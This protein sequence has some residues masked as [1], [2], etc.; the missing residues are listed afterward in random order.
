MKRKHYLLN[1][2][3]LLLCFSGRSQEKIELYKIPE[4][5]EIVDYNKT[6][7]EKNT[8]GAS[9]YLLTNWQSNLIRKTFFTHFA[10]KIN[11]NEGVQEMS[12]LDFSFD[13]SY[14]KINF[15]FINV[16]RD[17]RIINKITDAKIQTIQKEESSKRLLYDGSLTTI[18]NLKD[19]R[20]N[21]II[22]YAY[23]RIGMNPISKGSFSKTAYLEYTIPV[24]LI[25]H[26]IITSKEINYKTYSGAPTPKIK[27]TKYGTEYILI[28]TNSK[29]VIYDKNTPNWY[30]QQ[31]RV[32]FST[33]NNWND[34]V[35]WALPHYRYNSK[36]KPLEFTNARTTEHKIIQT[37]RF[38]QDEVRYLGFED[39]ISAYK[40][41]SPQKIYSQRYGDCKDKSLLLVTL[42]K[43]I[44]VKAYPVLVN[45]DSKQTIIN[46]LPSYNTFNHCIVQIDYQDQQYFI[47][48]TIS[49]QGGD[50]K[51]HENPNYFFG[52]VIKKGESNLTSI[53]VLQKASTDVK[54]TF[55]MDSIGGDCILEVVTTYKGS[56]AD[57]NRSYFKSNSY[58]EIQKKYTEFYSYQHPEIQ[59]IEEIEVEDWDRNTTN[60]FIVKEKYKIHNFWYDDEEDEKTIHCETSPLGLQSLIDYSKA[61]NRNMPYYLGPPK[62]YHHTTYIKVPEEWSITGFYDEVIDSSFTYKAKATYQNK[63]IT[64]TYDYDLKKHFLKKNEV[65]SFLEKHDKIYSETG[66]TLSYE[67]NSDHSGMSWHAIF[68]GLFTF[69]LTLYFLSK[70]YTDFNP[71]P[72]KYSN[73][74]LSLGGVLYFVPIGLLASLYQ[75]AISFH[76][77]EPFI[78]R[79]WIK[80]DTMPNSN[81][82]LMIASA[83]YMLHIFFIGFN[84][85]LLILFFKKRT[86]TSILTSAFYL[87]I[88]AIPMLLKLTYNLFA[89]NDSLDVFNDSS[90]IYLLAFLAWTGYFTYSERPKK[91][92]VNVY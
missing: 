61:P 66:F 30:N 39:G 79:S 31:K 70:I 82:L 6:T 12:D 46:K 13:P 57:K 64:V 27:D 10:I 54:K 40:P 35:N 9:S 16:I 22:E 91:T 59:P 43:N 15:H 65:S 55:K 49:N 3:L 73:L 80:Y 69:Y 17:G 42:L 8:Q 58:S 41:H 71:D 7:T 1:L 76:N 89:G 88:F 51:H 33:F 32:S 47:D 37:I 25:S 83:Q 75:L 78:G 72:F 85:L 38:V 2:I 45:T 77:K 20:K 18:F 14:E 4:W 60:E 48:P 24:K 26:R 36:L 44:G 63:V 21:D 74:H 81:T 68:L 90:V 92:F 28:A 19:I 5:V 23:S 86:S 62:T 67:K 84:I 50:L 56:E 34:I 53:P 11:N 29:E 52:L 87:A